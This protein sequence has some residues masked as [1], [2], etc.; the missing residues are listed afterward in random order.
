M[1]GLE[2]HEIDY[3]FSLFKEPLPGTLDP[4]AAN[5]YMQEQMMKIIPS[6]SEDHPEIFEKLKTAQAKTSGETYAVRQ[7]TGFP[8]R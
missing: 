3:I 8:N 2:D 5:H 6:L 1:E 7:T 4:F